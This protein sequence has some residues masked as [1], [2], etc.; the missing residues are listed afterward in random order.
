MQ[1]HL[2][3]RCATDGRSRRAAGRSGRR[4]SK[5]LLGDRIYSRNGDPLG[6]GGRRAAASRRTPPLAVAESCTGGMLGER[7]TS[8]AGSSR[9]FRGRLHHLL[10]RDEG[11]VAG[12][13]PGNSG[14][15]RRGQPRDRRSHGCGRRRR[16]GST[17]ALAITGVAG[18]D[19]GR[20]RK[21]LPAGTV[22]V[23]IA[24]PEG[25]R[26]VH[27]QFLGDRKRIRVF[28]TQMA[29]DL[30]RRQLLGKP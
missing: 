7:F 21:L 9:L 19:P 23:G 4:R 5:L 17:Y 1:V 11:G 10:E 22:Y 27:R 20:G 14:A 28:S 6:S 26:A 16:T 3:A 30:L 2:R 12:R 8:A 15:L 25:V 13:E 18:P 24:G 29:L